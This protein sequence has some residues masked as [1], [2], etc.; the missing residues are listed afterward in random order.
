MD[1]DNL[2]GLVRALQ[3]EILDVMELSETEKAYAAQIKET[4]KRV[5][6]SLG[7]SFRLDPSL[8]RKLPRNVTDV[9]L[10]PQGIFCLTYNDNSISTR[11]LEN[12]STESLLMVLERLLPEIEQEITDRHRKLIIRV[13]VLERIS[14]EIKNV[15]TI[16]PISAKHS[17]PQ[18]A[19]LAI[20]DQTSGLTKARPRHPD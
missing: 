15:P 10:S 7:R 8:F 12:L 16:G 17:G 6:S 13:A 11:S 18:Q 19:E 4:L 5:I 3:Q 9:V 20:D 2:P 1:L 14:N